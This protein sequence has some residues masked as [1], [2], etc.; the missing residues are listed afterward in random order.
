M[1]SGCKAL[2]VTEHSVRPSSASAQAV[3]HAFFI[4]E[5][6]AIISVSVSSRPWHFGL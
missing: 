3:G 2:G 4:K 6:D 5:G 1:A